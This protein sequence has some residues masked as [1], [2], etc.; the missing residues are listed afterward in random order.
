MGFNPAALNI[1]L[2]LGRLSP[3]SFRNFVSS[4]ASSADT[5]LYTSYDCCVGR[6]SRSAD[7]AHQR[8]DAV[9]QANRIVRVD[10]VRCDSW[11]DKRVLDDADRGA[12]RRRQPR[13]FALLRCR[14]LTGGDR[15]APP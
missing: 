10:P 2:I 1:A 8:A 13:E 12:E 3:I 14:H 4:L 11:S 7:H 5:T 6:P 9:V 15:R